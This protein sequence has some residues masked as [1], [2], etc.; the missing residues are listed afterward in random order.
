[1]IAFAH[2]CD[3]IAATTSRTAKVERLAAY[4]RTLDAADLPAAARFFTGDPFA[5]S[6]DRHA[7]IAGKT[8]VA[9]AQAV[10]YVDAERLSTTYRTTGDL[11]AAL[12]GFV[13]PTFDL[14]LF[15]ETLAPGRLAA[16][17]EEAA[18]AAGK[19][20]G[21][22]RRVICERILGACSEEL[23]ARYVVKVLTG[24]LRIG[25]REGLIADGIA[26]AF[27]ADPAAV[28]RAI[29]ASGDV[30]R[31]AAAARRQE[32][33]TIAVRY[34]AP[35]GPMLASPMP[36]GD[37]YA[38]LAGARWIVEDKYDGVRAQ[39]H[40]SAAGV[41][42]FSRTSSEITAA[43]PE[44]AA[45]FAEA[46]QAA[47]LDGEIVAQR[48]GRVLPFRA[49]QTR[50][51]RKD[52]PPEL[53]AEIPA[54]FV[55]FDVLAAGDRFVLDVPLEERRRLLG[56]TVAEGE[57]V[58]IAPS[59]ALDDASAAA[60]NERFAAARARGHEG[61]IFKRAD[62]SYAPGRR[63]KWWLK[64]KRELRTLDVVVVGVE[65]GHGR[66]AQ[67][68]SDYT[69]AVR[70]SAADATLRTI[71][72]A[73]SGL[74]DAEIAELTPWFLAHEIGR[75]RRRA[76]AVEPATVIEVA[77]DVV[78]ESALHDSGFSLRF[79]RIVRLRSD[80]P[81]SEI[82]TLETVREIYAEMTARERG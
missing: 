62:A 51:A 6:D 64:L 41:R 45:A 69:F 78:Q 77:F 43:F 10:W 15:R 3:E 40:A 79:P 68:L 36:Y 82:D 30:G 67:V 37:A 72:K 19:A 38:P 50:L 17:L 8:I 32:L 61:L 54:V 76:I 48:D 27:A 57:R 44:I 66:R 29:M 7:A 23:E 35:I 58:R 4:L 9:A 11:G 31:V 14:G 21:A 75:I 52:P 47:I 2:A 70:T 12:G 63:G 5:A 55:A 16:L 25:L 39:V 60:V 26:L 80:K 28:R 34:G 24:E 18:E 65:W 56:E 20:A 81:A 42:I 33:E 71:G 73:Y 13:R 49:L 1:L 59:S 46:P 53:L 22:K 74:T